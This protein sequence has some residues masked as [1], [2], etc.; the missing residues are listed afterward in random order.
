MVTM[1]LLAIALAG[2]NKAVEHTCTCRNF[3]GQV[4]EV[5]THYGSEDNARDLC[6]QQEDELNQNTTG[7][8]VFT[9]VL[10]PAL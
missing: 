5:D 7:V 10:D 9:C 3:D 2:C 8:D 1:A 4:V 6:A